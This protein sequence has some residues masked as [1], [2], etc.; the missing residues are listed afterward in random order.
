MTGHRCIL[1]LK[2][3]T[4]IKELL[5]LKSNKGNS[6]TERAVLGSAL[7]YACMDKHRPPEIFYI[8]LHIGARWALTSLPNSVIWKCP[9]EFRVHYSCSLTEPL[10]STVVL[11]LI[12]CLTC[13]SSGIEPARSGGET[14]CRLL[15]RKLFIIYHSHSLS[16]LKQSWGSLVMI[17]ALLYSLKISI[18]QFLKEVS[19]RFLCRGGLRK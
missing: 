8:I 3:R 10:Y 7:N 5:R 4:V 6:A 14:F 1:D 16:L 17:A 2:I 13:C 18:V 15:R 9:D 12:P 19:Q 11:P